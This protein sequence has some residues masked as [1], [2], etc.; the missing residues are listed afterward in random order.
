MT[1]ALVIG[2]TSGLGLHLAQ[3]LATHTHVFITGRKNPGAEGLEFLPLDLRSDDHLPTKISQ[4][5]HELPPISLLIYA[6]GYYQEGRITDLDESDI[7]TMLNVGVNGAIYVL[8]DVLRKQGD[9][10]GFIAITSTSQ[11]TPRLLEPIY[12][13]VKAGLGALANSI[14]LDERVKKTLVAGPA[15][16]KT[17]FW[18]N[19]PR[20]MTTYMEPDWVAEQ[21]L[22]AFEQ[23]FRYQYIKILR[24]PARVEIQ[25]TRE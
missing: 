12:T 9:L 6:A 17:A 7:Q 14:S 2:G 22:T 19:A 16:M 18:Q 8:R 10:D 21:I 4:L 3:R 23:D 11:Y 20:D 25:E 1:N 13:V 24:E 15:G 5:V